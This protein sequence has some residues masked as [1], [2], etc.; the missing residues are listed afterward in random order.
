[1][2]RWPVRAQAGQLVLADSGPSA[3]AGQQVAGIMTGWFEH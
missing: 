2:K 3:R 1:M